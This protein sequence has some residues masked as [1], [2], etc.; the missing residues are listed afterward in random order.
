MPIKVDG[1]FLGI[2]GN[3]FNKGSTPAI[4]VVEADKVGSCFV[5]QDH[6]NLPE[7]HHPEIPLEAKMVSGTNWENAEME[8][9]LIS[10]PTLVPIPFGIDFQLHT[11]DDA[12]VEE[13]EKFLSSMASGQR[14]WL[15]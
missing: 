2:M 8:I 7:N 13:M 14:F 15:M 1:N 5:I 11:I 3:L 10:L 6:D 12:F 9:S 4:T